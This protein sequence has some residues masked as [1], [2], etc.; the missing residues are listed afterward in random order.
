MMASQHTANT[1]RAAPAAAFRTTKP[2]RALT[3]RAASNEGPTPSSSSSTGA[4]SASA[5][6]ATKREV[7]GLG[8]AA[9]ALAVAPRCSGRQHRCF[10]YQTQLL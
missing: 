3:V 10:S 5:A 1:L 4:A 2:R 7:L 8:V 9:A 6:T